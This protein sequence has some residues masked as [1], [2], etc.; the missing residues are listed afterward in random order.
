ATLKDEFN[1]VEPYIA[2]RL[3]EWNDRS[4]GT[5]FKESSDRWLETFGHFAKMGIKLDCF[6][7]MVEYLHALPGHNA[8]VERV[9]SRVKLFWT[10]NKSQ[11]TTGAV[12]DFAQVSFNFGVED[13]SAM[14][15]YIYQRPELCHDI[16]SS[17]KY[18]RTKQLLINTDVDHMAQNEL[19][20]YASDLDGFVEV[21]VDVQG[22]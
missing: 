11:M 22:M 3:N 19:D 4:N 6:R 7:T 15:H 2:T 16:Q 18:H 12:S 10:D 14:F 1:L 5:C 9:F 13:S 21:V 8:S 20:L 17:N